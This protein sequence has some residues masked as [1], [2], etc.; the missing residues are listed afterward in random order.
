MKILAIDVSVKGC[1]A[2]FLDSESS[3]KLLKY[4]ETDRGQAERLIPMIGELIEQA[5]LQMSD[6]DRM[7]VTRGP[8]SFTGVRIGLATARTL[9]MALSIPV[10][11]FSTLETILSSHPDQKNALAIIDTKRGD[12]YGQTTNT[13]SRIYSKGET[14]AWSGHKIVD[15]LPDL[16]FMANQAALV[17]E[18][19]FNHYPALPIYLREAET[20]TPK[21]H[22]TVGNQTERL[23]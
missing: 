8:G 2:A 10:L 18:S 3:E 16:L 9:G 14:E 20:S 17:K 22:S 13:S 19:E 7:A 21:E 1:S 12:F 23:S 6:M 15:A 5:S 4:E 11:G